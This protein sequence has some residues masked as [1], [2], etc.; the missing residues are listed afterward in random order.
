[1]ASIRKQVEID[2]PPDRVWDAIHDFGALH[3]RFVRGFVLDTRLDGDVRIVTFASGMVQREPLV[4]C[5]DDIRRLVYTAVDSP[6]GV[7]HYNAAVQV[8]PRG[9]AGAT[10]EWVV[11]VL[12]NDLRDLLDGAMD[13]GA[14]AMKRT[15]EEG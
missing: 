4:T 13:Q 8:F 10:I 2:A 15:L 11:D 12:P 7:T 9:A 5:D 3:T 14:A 1:M 6:L